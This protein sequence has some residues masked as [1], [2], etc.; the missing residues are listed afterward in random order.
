MLLDT[1]LPAFA[2]ITVGLFGVALIVFWVWMLVDC[3]Q[4]EHEDRW[5][6]AAWVAVIVLTKL[7]GAAIYYFMRYRDR[8]RPGASQVL[9][10][11]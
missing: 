10:T 7:F 11:V 5:E 8:P 2:A 6:L 4:R 3:L 9:G 1:L